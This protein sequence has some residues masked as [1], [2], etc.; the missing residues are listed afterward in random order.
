[1]ESRVEQP[2]D[3]VPSQNLDGS[4][5]RAHRSITAAAYIGLLITGIL[6]MYA[7]TFLTI[8]LVFLNASG[9]LRA[10][11][12]G[13][14]LEHLTHTMAVLKNPLRFSVFISQFLFMLLP[15]LWIV[16]RWHTA[17]V[18]SYVRFSRISFLELGIAVAATVCFIPV[19]GGISDFFMKQLNVPDFLA[20]INAQIF[21]SYSVQELLWLVVVVCITPALCEEVLFRGYFQRTLERTLGM[22]SLFIAGI[23]FGLYHMQPLNLISL[24]LL[25]CMFGY[26]FYRSKSLLPGIAAHLVNN[27]LAV[28][29]LY[30]TP[31]GSVVFDV[32]DF[33]ITFLGGVAALVLTG[34]LLF[35]YQ[36]I[37]QKNFEEHY[38]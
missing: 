17:H 19:S 28:L 5:E 13:N 1:M 26:F 30:K 27:L 9:E 29:S 15:I 25:G 34:G 36:Q 21:T 11:K 18:L 22:K 4:W 8:I 2:S 3:T 12:G 16:K 31:D 37:T 7:Q 24:A 14:F 32:F 33:E 10:F 23:I 35:M 20:Q 6:Y 38:G